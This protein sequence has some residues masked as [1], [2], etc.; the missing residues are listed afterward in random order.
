MIPDPNL[1]SGD[2]S[3]FA[4]WTGTTL[5]V[6]YA[7][8]LALRRWLSGDGATRAENS[9]GTNFMQA[10]ME[11]LE[12]ANERADQF[13]KERNAAIEVIGELKAQVAALEMTV[14]HL[15]RQI[16]LVICMPEEK[17]ED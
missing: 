5:A 10:L 3:R 6:V 15:Q 13:A 14:A 8:G 11:Q 1:L 9:L 4:V 7:A 16:D 12:K 2:A 17:D